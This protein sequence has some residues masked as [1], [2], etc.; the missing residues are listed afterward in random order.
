M[1]YVLYQGSVYGKLTCGYFCIRDVY[2]VGFVQGTHMWYILFE[3]QVNGKFCMRD[4]YVLGFVQGKCMQ[5]C[6]RGVC[7]V[8]FA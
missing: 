8:G 5:C 1:W 7:V 4:A 3:E 2:V 6:M